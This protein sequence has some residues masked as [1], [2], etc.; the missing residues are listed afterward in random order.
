MAIGVGITT[1]NRSTLL[2]LIMPQWINKSAKDTIFVVHIDGENNRGYEWLQDYPYVHV[3]RDGVRKG[4]AK[5]KNACMDYLQSQ[6]CEHIFMSDDDFYPQKAGWEQPFLNSDMLHSCY[7]TAIDGGERVT[8]FTEKDNSFAGCGG[9]LLYFRGESCN[10]RYLEGYGIYGYEHVE[11]SERL[12]RKNNGINQPYMPDCWIAP[13]DIQGMFY[14]FDFNYNWRGEMPCFDLGGLKVT[15]SL[16]G[17]DT[18]E[19]I[20]ISA[21]YHNKK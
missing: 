15:T 9:V 21:E 8:H 1:Y 18:D 13:K 11:L 5:S 14:S 12:W 10:E 17:E 19:Y 6:G 4:I 3:I 2:R 20:R 16:Q 7:I